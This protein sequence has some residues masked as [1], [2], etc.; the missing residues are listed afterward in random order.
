MPDPRPRTT[1]VLPVLD[2]DSPVD[3]RAFLGDAARLAALAVLV[4]ACGGGDDGPTGNDNTP[5]ANPNQIDVT[6][7]LAA[8]P[9][10]GAVGGI[11]RTGTG[12]RSVAVVREATDRFRAFSLI[13]PHAGTIVNIEGSGFVCPNHNS[14]FAA[15]GAVTRGPATRGLSELTAAFDAAAGSVRVTGTV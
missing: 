3:R 10:L 1:R 6:L 4:A 11:A 8:N 7:T 9:A 2:G 14:A 12:N 15:S 13:C 5:P